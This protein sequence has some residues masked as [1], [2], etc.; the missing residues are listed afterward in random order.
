MKMKDGELPNWSGQTYKIC[1]IWEKFKN[2][3]PIPPPGLSGMYLAFHLHV[4]LTS[5]KGKYKRFRPFVEII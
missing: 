2:L 3:Y 4:V 5:F 1:C